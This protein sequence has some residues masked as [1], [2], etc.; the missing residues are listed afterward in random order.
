MALVAGYAGFAAFMAQRLLS[1]IAVLA[2]LYLLVVLTHAALVERLG[3]DTP[4][5]R[6]LAVNFGVNPRRLGLLRASW[7]AASACC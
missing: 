4:R 5:S 2:V 7:R 6:A 1:T 3:A